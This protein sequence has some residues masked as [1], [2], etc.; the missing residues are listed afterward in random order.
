M[1]RRE[2]ELVLKVYKDC[3]K[4]KRNGKLTEY[5]E[6]Q[7]DLCRMLLHEQDQVSKGQK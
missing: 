4:L 5:G 3:L 1:N 6:G 2:N 7:M